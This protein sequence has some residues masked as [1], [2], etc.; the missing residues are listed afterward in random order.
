MG[1]FD[2][3]T[4][5]VLGSNVGSIDIVKYARKEG[6]YTIVADYYPSEKS[7]AKKYAHENVLVSTADIQSLSELIEKRHVNGVLAGISE[8]NL[9]SA[10]KLSEK[11]H[12][13]FYCTKQQWNLIEKKNSFRLLCQKYNVPCP[14]TY[15][16]DKKSE[17]SFFNKVVYPVIV[18]PV[19]S[20]ASIGVHIC[21]S[22][23][24]LLN[25]IPDAL[26]NSSS[27][28][29][30]VEEY[31]DGYEFTAH[32]TVA[33]GN[34]ILSSIDNRYPVAV[35]TGN[36]T[37]IP[38]ARIYPCLFIDEYIKQ[39]NTSM[40]NLCNSLLL[41]NAIIFI[42]GIY[43]KKK[44]KFYIF[45]GGL[46]SAAEAPYRF[47]ER[48]NGNNSLKLLVDHALSA[49]SDFKNDLED[50]KLHGKC[51]GVVSFIATGGTVGKIVGL[52]Q[53]V[54]N[55]PSVIEY[56]KRY[57]EGDK[58]PTGNTL[59]Q[60]MIRF[61]MICNERKE[62]IKDIQYLNDN[63]NVLDVEGKNMVIKLNPER[64]LDIE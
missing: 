28:Q 31:I 6:A 50:P 43:N 16:I 23:S 62:M 9:I 57:N 3:K 25:S 45:E 54:K 47:I 55:T 21:Y 5:L 44:N 20:S 36:V 41:E 48:I 26:K 10:M 2:N 27:N 56:E 46:R 37:T 40:I 17:D 58:T 30:I 32:Y 64:I 49:K 19:D 59:R 39:V 35:N 12:L 63:I 53:A 14:K 11:H 13:P 34:A 18:K 1:K 42:Q 38:V 51:C 52:E 4:L 8:F 61:V 60:I 33:Q 7:P 29:I 24:D 15:L 22:K